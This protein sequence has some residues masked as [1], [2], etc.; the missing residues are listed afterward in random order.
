LPWWCAGGCASPSTAAIGPVVDVV[1]AHLPTLR[2]AFDDET[3]EVTAPIVCLTERGI[4]LSDRRVVDNAIH[5]LG[6]EQLVHR[7]L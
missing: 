6:T 5:E 7:L 3:V 4:D 1:A 2:G